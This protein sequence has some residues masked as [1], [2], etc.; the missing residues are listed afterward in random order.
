MADVNS[1]DFY[2]VLGVPRTATEKE[3]KK[4]YRKLAIRYH[5][6]KNKDDPK[7]AAEVFK[8]VSEAYDTLSDKQK[9]AGYDRFGKQVPG[10]PGGGGGGNPFSGF[11][12]GGGDSTFTMD[13]ADD[14]FKAFFGG[15][16]PFGGGG[17]GGGGFGGA[18]MD[19]GLPRGVF[20]N[21]MGG[22]FPM[23]G[24]GMGG[25]GGMGGG[26]RGGFPGGFR[27][28]QQRRTEPPKRLD[29]ID[30]G[31]GVLVKGLRGAAE[32]NGRG[33]VIKSFDA[34][35]SRYVVA[36]KDGPTLRLSRKNVQQQVRNVKIT[37]IKSRQE[38]NGATCIITNYDEDK[39]R[40]KVRLSNG[41]SAAM[42][43][44]NVIL[45]QGTCVVIR[46]LST[47]RWN[48]TYGKI[49]KYDSASG[50]Y[51]IKVSPKQILKIRSVNVLA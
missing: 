5:P 24:M 30:V 50:K 1:D 35:K 42:K 13:Q 43:P 48:G 12:G 4:A 23:G 33:G 25:M 11:G 44:E 7:A 20:G 46:N 39:G 29:A 41:S 22:G 40:Y 16:S 19:G 47:A 21:V 6:D 31:T 14:I 27:Q 10:M 8:K 45:P 9:R 15:G 37:G 3:I 17:F 51:S 26:M 49:E 38:L 28:Q 34:S 18:G 36:I 2:K 32:H